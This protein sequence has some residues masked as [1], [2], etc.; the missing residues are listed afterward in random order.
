VCTSKITLACEL[1]ARVVTEAEEKRALNI[2]DQHFVKIRRDLRV[3][4]Q[5]A[6][7]KR[8]RAF[9][10]EASDDEILRADEQIACLEKKQQAAEQSYDDDIEQVKRDFSEARKARQQTTHVSVVDTASAG[11]RV[12]RLQ[13]WL[14]WK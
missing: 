1:T 4:I 8:E 3:D 12:S 5:D 9:Q 10:D 13:R 11:Q 7:D 14:W 2:V 6:R